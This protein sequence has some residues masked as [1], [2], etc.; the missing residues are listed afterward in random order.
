[1]R[2]R[3]LFGHPRL[4]ST[5][6]EIGM[7]QRYG[8]VGRISFG[9]PSCHWASVSQKGS[10]EQT[11]GGRRQ[12]IATTTANEATVPLLRLIQLIRLTGL[13]CVRCSARRPGVL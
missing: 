5:A 9:I 1:M 10:S 8:V 3:S 4:R 6:L 2:L 12:S 11:V 7:T 13:M